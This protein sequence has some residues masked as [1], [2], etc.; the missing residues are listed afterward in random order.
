VALPDPT[1]PDVVRR[2]PRVTAAVVSAL[3]YTVV[4]GTLAGDAPAWLYPDIT[5]AQVDLL[6]HLIA[7]VNAATTVVL[8][9]GWHWIRRDRVRRHAA[10]MTAAFVLILVFLVLYLLKTGGGGTKEFIGPPLAR[11]VYLVTLGVHILLSIVAVPVVVYALTLGLVHTPAEL[12]E[13][14]PHRLAGRLAAGSWIVSLTLGLVAYVLLNHVY[15]ATFV[16]ATLL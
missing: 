12:R 3:G 6:S 16:P 9:A 10:A 1:G 15:D 8:I 2:H 4:I 14:T 5:R 7:G 11:R 13:A